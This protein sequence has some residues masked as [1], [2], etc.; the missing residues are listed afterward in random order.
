MTIATVQKRGDTHGASSESKL[1][2]IEVRDRTP[3]FSNQALLGHVNVTQVQGMV[4]SL[5]LPHFDEPDADIFS[6]CLQDS[7]AMVLRLVQHL[8][9]K[10]GTR[11]AVRYSVA[12]C[13]GQ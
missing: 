6:S 5:H 4:D 10:S 9:W 2:G 8:A 13:S 11:T 12:K 3:D 1:D 7:L